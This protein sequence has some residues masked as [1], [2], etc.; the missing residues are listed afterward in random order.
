MGF[1]FILSG[2]FSAGVLE[3]KSP[4]QVLFQRLIR[5][6]IPI[7]FFMYLISP[8]LRLLLRSILFNQTP[9]LAGLK[10]IYRSLDFRIELGPMWFVILLLIFSIL[11]IPWNLLLK[12]LP[13]N[14]NINFFAQTG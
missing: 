13:L 8:V 7:L 4:Y 14:L 11:Y 6:G 10:V 2:Y 5:L 9:S 3:R 12:K 1:F